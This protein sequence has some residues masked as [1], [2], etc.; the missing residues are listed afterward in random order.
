MLK[1]NDLVMAK[2]EHRMLIY[3][4]MLILKS[5]LK[6]LLIKKADHQKELTDSE[7]MLALTEEFIRTKLDLLDKNVASVF[8]EIKFLNRKQH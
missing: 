3:T 6:L 5:K 8:G 2:E 7:I 1:F 4:I